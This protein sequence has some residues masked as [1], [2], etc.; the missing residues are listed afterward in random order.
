MLPHLWFLD[1]FLAYLYSLLSPH[2]RYVLSPFTVLWPDFF[3]WLLLEA[4]KPSSVW[5]FFQ[6]SSK[7]FW[8]AYNLVFLMKLRSL[9]DTRICFR[10]TL[11]TPSGN[12]SP[13]NSP[14]SFNYILIAPLKKKSVWGISFPFGTLF[15]FFDCFSALSYFREVVP[16]LRMNNTE[17]H[18]VI[19][20]NVKNS[21]QSKFS[22]WAIK[23]F[24]SGA[25]E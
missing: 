8:N 12:C 9:F 16:D 21:Y 7:I 3:F 11:L 22:Q 1:E 24:L 25:N 17:Q 23:R 2:R 20:G 18:P 15:S 6:T 4:Q 14:V 13:L 5:A 19:L 10:S